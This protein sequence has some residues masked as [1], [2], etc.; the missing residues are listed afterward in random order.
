MTWMGRLQ[1]TVS[2]DHVGA[3]DLTTIT[4]TG[5]VNVGTA[6][7]ADAWLEANALSGILF[8]FIGNSTKLGL[9]RLDRTTRRPGRSEKAEESGLSQ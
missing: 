2:L 7:H 9:R 4:G 3:A 5:S 6:G 1:T 8:L